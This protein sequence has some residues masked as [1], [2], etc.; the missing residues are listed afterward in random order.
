MLAVKHIQQRQNASS[1]NMVL[2]YQETEVKPRRPARRRPET[3]TSAEYPARQA[4]SALSGGL[5]I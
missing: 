4:V 2:A 3:R 1:V 5:F